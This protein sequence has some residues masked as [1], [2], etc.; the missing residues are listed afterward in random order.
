MSNNSLWKGEHGRIFMDKSKL[1]LRECDK[2]NP[3]INKLN[4]NKFSHLFSSLLIFLNL[5][6]GNLS[7][8][9]IPFGCL[10]MSNM[11]MMVVMVHVMVVF[12]VRVAEIYADAQTTTW[13]FTL[14]VF[15]VRFLL[16]FGNYFNFTLGINFIRR[17]ATG[18]FCKMAREQFCFKNFEQN[19]QVCRSN[20]EQ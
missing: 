5:F 3:A 10:H 20:F 13:S 17:P 8:D 1:F 7:F 12:V 2:C 19:D 14:F 16:R 11:V 4:T 9:F 6:D 15:F 18:H